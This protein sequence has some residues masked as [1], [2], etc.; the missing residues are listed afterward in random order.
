[1]KWMEFR[2][3]M[4]FLCLWSSK[5]LAPSRV[6]RRN[7][8]KT[9]TVHSCCLFVAH[10]DSS[11]TVCSSWVRDFGSDEFILSAAAAA[12]DDCSVVGPRMPP[13]PP[14]SSRVSTDQTLLLHHHH[15]HHH[16]H[17]Q[18]PDCVFH[19]R[20]GSLREPV[21][22]S[23]RTRRGEE[24]GQGGGPSSD[25]RGEIVLRNKTRQ[26]IFAAAR[27]LPSR[28]IPSSRLTVTPHGRHVTARI[29]IQPPSAAAHNNMRE[30]KSVVQDSHRALRVSVK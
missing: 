14:P 20:D 24:A 8:D 10:N 3:E 9:H 6:T 17:R 26:L 5:S 11:T 15:R 2:S 22:C 7:P 4:Y 13:P 29:T 30:G 1:M 18:P 19:R 23:R 21:S 27:C 12:D 25:D 16:Q 28:L